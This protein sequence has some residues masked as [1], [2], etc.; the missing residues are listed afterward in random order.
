MSGVW[1]KRA[2]D[3][4]AAG[5]EAEGLR[6]LRGCVRVV[7]LSADGTLVLERVLPGTT[8]LASGLD[9]DAMTRVLA[10]AMV[11]MHVRADTS[12]PTVAQE[13]ARLSG[14]AAAVLR[15]L[16]VGGPA[17]VVLHG[18]LHHGNL[19]C[20]PDGWVGIDPHGVVGDPGYDVGPLLLNAL[21][22]DL[23]RQADRR[24]GVLAEVLGQDRDR[25]QAW[26]YVRACLS[27]S[28]SAQDGTPP[29]PGVEQLEQVLRPGRS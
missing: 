11:G 16:L 14:D 25:L 5:R 13:C 3:L 22:A 12:L 17:D 7:E 20:G 4:A 9:D 23:A 10:E 15:E 8:L 19:L 24:L 27:R 26:G 1:R 2:R 6:V 18:D 29:L 21:A 28:W